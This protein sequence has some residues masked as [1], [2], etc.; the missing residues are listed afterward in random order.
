VEEW[1]ILKPEDM[2]SRP[3][4]VFFISRRKPQKRRKIPVISKTCRLAVEKPG[5]GNEKLP[6]ISGVYGKLRYMRE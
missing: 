1:L 5:V 4:C 6:E 2:G 3:A